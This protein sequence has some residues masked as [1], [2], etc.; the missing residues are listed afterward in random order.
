MR[1]AYVLA[2]V[3]L[4]WLRPYGG[5]QSLIADTKGPLDRWFQI[6][7]HTQT[8]QPHWIAPVFTPTARLEQM[9]VYDVSRQNTAKGDV[10]NLGGTKGL[11]LI[12]NEHINFVLTP[13]AYFAHENAKIHDGFGDMSF[14]LKYRLAAANEEQ[15]N[16]VVTAFVSTT[17]ATG[18]YKNGAPHAMINPS[19][20][21]GKGWGHFD[22]QSTLGVGVPVGDAGKLGTPF[23]Y[24]TAFQYVVLKKIWP[25]VEING[26]VFPNGPNAGK[27][28]IFLSPG[29]MFGKLHLWR[30]LGFA[31]GGGV[32][33]AATHF[34][35]FN[36]NRVLTLRFPF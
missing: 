25:E 5:G 10:T 14:L 19:V 2:F 11:L 26:T 7:A 28:Q 24:N 29:L 33:I 15:G 6:V 32:Q 18:A 20:G 9:F 4:L 30:R 13:P 21:F 8:E 34:H 16:Y 35:T 27:T 1:N 3:L 17:I 23:S 36:H 31:M 22:V 12:P